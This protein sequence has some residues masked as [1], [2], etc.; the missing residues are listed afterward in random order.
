MAICSKLSR[1][2][3]SD[4]L[5][6]LEELTESLRR[7]PMDKSYAGGDQGDSRSCIVAQRAR[8]ELA[9]EALLGEVAHLS[10]QVNQC[11]LINRLPIEIFIQIFLPGVIDDIKSH[12]PLRI[13]LF[14]ITIS[15][16]CH[17]WREIAL[18]SPTLWTL[19]HPSHPTELVARAKAIPRDVVLTPDSLSIDVNPTLMNMQSL[20]IVLPDQED[21]VN[22]TQLMSHPAPTLSALYLSTTPGC[23]RGM[24]EIPGHPFEGEHCLEVVSIRNCGINWKT[25]LLVGLQRLCLSHIDIAYWMGL[26]EL[27]L[28]LEACP[29]LRDLDLQECGFYP[30][31]D[32]EN[33]RVSLPRLTNVS[34]QGTQLLSHGDAFLSHIL[35]PPAVNLTIACHY[36]TGVDSILPPAHVAYTLPVSPTLRSLPQTIMS[37]CERLTLSITTI[38]RH[39]SYGLAFTY[40][41]GGITLSFAYTRPQ[42]L[43]QLD[44]LSP[45]LSNATKLKSLHMT[46]FNRQESA[47]LHAIIRSIPGLKDVCFEWCWGD[48]EDYIFNALTAEEWTQPIKRIILRHS[49]NSLVSLV[50]FAQFRATISELLPIEVLLRSHR[51]ADPEALNALRT[52][53]TVSLES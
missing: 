50:Q 5:R 53:A 21:P 42:L 3:S 9:A 14:A 47:K 20:R 41:D 40:D 45:L 11:S 36:L 39:T 17:F 1:G 32:T 31:V 6:L 2:L 12:K 48:C 43:E 51:E 18:A 52:L 8:F 27:L 38:C 30:A 37:N 22:L 29:E 33:I 19:L 4:S 25:N 46:N 34:W 23:D 44:R 13:P 49:H 26:R 16:V 10:R 28:I 24:A 7:H 35:A 15:H